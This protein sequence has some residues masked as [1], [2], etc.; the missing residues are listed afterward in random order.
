MDF[1]INCT[2][3]SQ[4]LTLNHDHSSLLSFFAPTKA[5]QNINSEQSA[6]LSSS[7]IGGGTVA[8]ALDISAG[9]YKHKE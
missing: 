8:V 3:N 7:R 9:L 4:T 1:R 2:K 6:P 5:L